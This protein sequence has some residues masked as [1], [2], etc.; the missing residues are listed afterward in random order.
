MNQ[1]NTVAASQVATTAE[2]DDTV[3]TTSKP[4]FVR[5]TSVKRRNDETDDDQQVRLFLFS[6]S[7]YNKNNNR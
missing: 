4:K 1:R 7:F 3:W 2:R 5:Q 6:L